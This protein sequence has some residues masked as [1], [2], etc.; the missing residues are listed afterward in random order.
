MPWRPAEK[1]SC[2]KPTWFWPIHFT[3]LD[4]NPV[5]CS[6]PELSLDVRRRTRQC[7]LG[8]LMDIE[9]TEAATSVSLSIKCKYGDG[10]KSPLHKGFTHFLKPLLTII[11]KGNMIKIIG[12][13]A[14]LPGFECQTYQPCDH[15]QVTDPFYASSGFSSVKWILYD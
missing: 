14:R 7:K 5:L 8:E 4:T 10:N 2:M 6:P 13:G 11:M 15:G 12:S 3:G 1:V 9:K